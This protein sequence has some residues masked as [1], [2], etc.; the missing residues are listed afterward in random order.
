MLNKRIKSVLV[1]GLLILGITGSVSAEETKDA[2]YYKRFSDYII[3]Q[4]MTQ[5]DSQGFK[6][7]DGDV[8]LIDEEFL[9]TK[10]DWIKFIENINNTKEDG[11]HI[12]V[13]FEYEDGKKA[14]CEVYTDPDL[15]GT[16]TD[17]DKNGGINHDPFEVLVVTYSDEEVEKKGWDNLLENLPTLPTNTGQTLAVGGIVI[18]AAA[19]VGLLVNN[20]KRKDEE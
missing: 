13:D 12:V 11:L 8:R 7:F 15:D 16:I 18:G 19:A 3:E 20:R 6:K 9:V 5:M 10:T 17:V 4:Y 14:Y 1:A 2:D